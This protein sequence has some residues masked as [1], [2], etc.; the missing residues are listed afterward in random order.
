MATNRLDKELLLRQ[1]VS[2]R[3]QAEDYIK[4]GKVSVNGSV[5]TKPSFSVSANDKL[6]LNIV[7]EYVSRAGL[8]LA[9]VYKQLGV[10][11]EDKVVLDVGSSTGGFTDFAL[12]HGAKKV[13][14]VDVGTDQLHEKIRHNSKVEVHEKT[15]IRGFKPSIRPDVVVMDV[16]FISSR[17]ILPHL[18][19]IT[20][21][22]T[23]FIIM[24]KPQ[25]EAG[26]H[27]IN[28]GVIKNSKIRRQIL[29]DFERWLSENRY[30]I[31][32]KADSQVAGAKGNIERFY[33][34]RSA[35]KI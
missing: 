15:D 16:S 20:K 1:T 27:Q 28:K 19:T 5:V 25:F 8:K 30:V 2:S 31:K 17:Y 11:F 23:D 35:T 13:I 3:S 4:R 12:Q 32:K 22:D 6:K 7:E 10:I 24:V 14:D 29:Q 21:K 26:K 18:L 33:Y 34:L 9:S